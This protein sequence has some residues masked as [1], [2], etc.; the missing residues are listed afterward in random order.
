MP[1]T[2]T[3][4]FPHYC[5][6]QSYTNTISE[7]MELKN[8]SKSEWQFSLCYMTFLCIYK[9]SARVR[10]VPTNHCSVTSTNACFNKVSWFLPL[11][12]YSTPINN[13]YKRILQKQT[14]RNVAVTRNEHQSLESCFFAL[15]KNS[16]KT[17]ATSLTSRVF[18]STIYFV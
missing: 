6:K 11:K 12:S 18:S 16:S 7:F 14:L 8:F 13:V 3:I 17:T 4:N 1:P 10:H 5:H 15:V 9:P 2:L